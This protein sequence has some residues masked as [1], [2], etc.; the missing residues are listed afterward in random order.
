[1]SGNRWQFQPIWLQLILVVTLGLAHGVGAQGA[2]KR[3]STPVPVTFGVRAL[4]PDTQVNTKVAFVSQMLTLPQVVCDTCTEQDTWTRQWSASQM[5]LDRDNTQADEG[6]YVFNSGLKGIG[7]SVHAE[8][9][10]RQTTSGEGE[11]LKESGELTVG[12]VRVGR[13]TGAGLVD[14]PAAEFSRVTTF[15]G[16]DGGVKYV[17]EDTFRVSADFRVPTCTSS[18]GSLTM[19]LPEVDKGWLMKNVAPGHF[20]ESMG[21]GSELV[22][23][24]CSENTRNLR[25]SFIPWGSVA[26]SVAGPSTLLVGYD[27]NKQDTGGGFAMKFD[28][29]GFGQTQ[30]GVVTWNQAIPLVLTNP[31]P[32][33]TNGDS[34]P[35]S[36]TVSLQA[37]YARPDNGLPLS[38]GQISA[39]GAYQVS[40]D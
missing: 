12:L 18:T 13:D 36:I 26:D 31:Q 30:R 1:M 8:P 14:L 35:E 28:A 15:R 6:W 27:E 24:N 25:V 34:L 20:A 29:K 37:F 11:Q 4:T 38:A 33:D 40:Y 22:I 3:K 10:L 2:V 39:K 21:S 17:Q 16:P 7:I 5:T 32:L 9:R 23:A 19:T